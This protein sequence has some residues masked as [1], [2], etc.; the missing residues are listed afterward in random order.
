MQGE[1]KTGAA[2]ACLYWVSDYFLSKTLYRQA[3][4]APVF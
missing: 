4:A 3:Q 2:C 1:S